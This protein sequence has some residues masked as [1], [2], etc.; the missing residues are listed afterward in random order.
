MTGSPGEDGMDGAPGLNGINGT[1]GVNGTNGI[2][3]PAGTNQIIATNLYFRDGNITTTGNALAT[4]TSTASCNTGD[5]VIHGTYNINNFGGGPF[6]NL[7]S[8]TS[9]TFDSY[10]VTVRATG[11]TI[12]STALC[13]NNP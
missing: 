5:I 1:N 12:Q 2:Q 10:S 7:I 8:S 4:I 6:F 11:V 9:T 13:F 3:G